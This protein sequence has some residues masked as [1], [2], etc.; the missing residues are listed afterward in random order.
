MGGGSLSWVPGPLA[1]LGTCW[2]CRLLDAS[3]DLLNQ[4]LWGGTHQAVF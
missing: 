1:E 4:E 2:K 3:A